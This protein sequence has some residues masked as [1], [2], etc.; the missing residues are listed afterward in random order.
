M[1]DDKQW[2]LYNCHKQVRAAKILSISTDIKILADYSAAIVLIT[3]SDSFDA[4][5]DFWGKHQ[6]KV[7]GYIVQ[8]LDENGNVDY[9]SYSPAK[10]FES[11]YTL[12][13]SN[14]VNESPEVNLRSFLMTQMEK[15]A[16]KFFP[17]INSTYKKIQAPHKKTKL[18]KEIVESNVPTV[19]EVKF[20]ISDYAMQVLAEAADRKDAANA[21]IVKEQK[22]NIMRNELIAHLIGKIFFY[23]DFKVETRSEKELSNLLREGGFLYQSEKE[24]F[25]A[26]DKYEQLSNRLI[27]TIRDTQ[28]SREKYVSKIEK[29]TVVK[30]L[31]VMAGIPEF[32]NVTA[33][34]KRA[35]GPTRNGVND[36]ILHFIG[37]I[38]FYSDFKPRIFSQRYLDK[39]LRM[40]GFRYETE[41]ELKAGVNLY[42]TANTPNSPFMKDI[43]IALPE[44]FKK[45]VNGEGYYWCHSDAPKQAR[46]MTSSFIHVD[47]AGYFDPNKH[48]SVRSII[49]AVPRSNE[50]GI[51]ETCNSPLPKAEERTLIEIIKE[52]IKNSDDKTLMSISEILTVGEKITKIRAEGMPISQEPKYGI[53]ENRLYNRA[54]GE[55]IP[56]D[57][58]VFIFRA[59][60]KLAAGIIRRYAGICNEITHFKAVVARA[61]SFHQFNDDHP[62][63][64]KE[65]DTEVVETPPQEHG[66]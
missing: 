36:F 65:P 11:G 64:M 53:R 4:N 37:K 22:T 49:S 30:I 6:P 26:I 45:E 10:P 47:D 19:K 7:G 35:L 23:G 18:D 32:T 17:L 43:R 31:E 48:T 44:L 28:E 8:Y 66:V 55:F 42:E 50:T 14:R 1:S 41:E 27:A 12:T 24:I 52:T 13:E 25:E 61:S 29:D 20:P 16:A 56:F 46:G 33:P 9:T 63:R 59:R 40:N 38:L 58:P 62:E 39:Q 51:T 60:D 21:T 2:P 57:E 54:S 34:L 3:D 5:P 15:N